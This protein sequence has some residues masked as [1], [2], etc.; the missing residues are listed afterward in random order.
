MEDKTV[1]LNGRIQSI[2]NILSQHEDRFDHVE[3]GLSD[4]GNEIEKLSGKQDKVSDKLDTHTESINQLRVKLPE[5]LME[6]VDE[7]ARRT[8]EIVDN[9]QVICT[10]SMEKRFVV[11]P[12]GWK[13]HVVKLII[14]GLGLLFGLNTG[15][16]LQGKETTPAPTKQSTTFTLKDQFG[17]IYQL[18][19][20]SVD[21]HDKKN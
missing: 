7:N 13:G 9:H 15:E 2:E 11:M 21:E 16:L 8:K 10:S 1:E 17:H 14:I 5:L 6:S 3:K 18:N 19:P 12:E 4:M 20:V